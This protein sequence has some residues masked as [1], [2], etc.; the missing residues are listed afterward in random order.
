MKSNSNK[1]IIGLFLIPLAIASILWAGDVDVR[2]T[3]NNGSTNFSVLD[4]GGVEVSSVNSDGA[5]YFS[6]ITQVSG[7]GGNV[8]LSRN[9]L[10]SGTTIYVASGTVTG[11]LMVDS[12]A[13]AAG[14]IH[15][16]AA[17]LASNNETAERSVYSFSVPGGT[18][19]S[20][21]TIRVVMMGSYTNNSGANR[22]IRLRFKYGATTIC[23]KTSANIATSGTTGDFFAEFILMAAGATNA[24]RA[25]QSLQIDRA[26]AIVGPIIDYGTATV[27]S[28]AAQTLDITVLHSGLTANFTKTAAYA[29]LE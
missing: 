7:T 6:S 4:S 24:Q 9:T 22:T 27:D 13:R 23:D 12:I 5:G 11:G 29:V 25:V 14:E 1:I 19:S 15:R 28:T 3:T 17:D 20:N 8:I 10:Q 26:G 18:L 21:R 2:L 16:D